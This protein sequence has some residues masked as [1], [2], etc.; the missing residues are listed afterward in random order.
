MTHGPAPAT[1]DAAQP[2]WSHRDPV[3][4]SEPFPPGTADHEAWTTATETARGR[5]REM[6]AAMVDS[7]QITLDPIVYRAQLF[8]LATGR[9][10]IWTERG[11]AAVSAAAGCLGYE[12][13][14]DR[15]VKNWLEYVADTCPLVEGLDEL[16][17]RLRELARRRV[18]EARRASASATGSG[19]RVEVD[20]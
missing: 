9:F 13:W 17:H 15:Y 1:F 12:R 5:L 19:A 4:G 7:A 10:A 2:R 16:E 18:R 11:L 6:D 14:L 20:G 8:D 3:E